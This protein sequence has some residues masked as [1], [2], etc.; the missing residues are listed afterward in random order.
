VVSEYQYYEFAA[1]DRP[2]D[3]RQLTAVW[4]LS[5]RA[6]VTPTSFVNTYEWGGFSGDPRRMVE[7]YYVAFLYLANWGTHELILRFAARLLGL[8]VVQRYCGREAVSAWGSGG[9]V[10]VACGIGG[11]GADPEALLRGGGAQ[12]DEQDASMACQAA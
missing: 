4:A 3:E 2:L 11:R 12:G 9:H 6:H 8:D 5:T 10:V 7:R 1:V